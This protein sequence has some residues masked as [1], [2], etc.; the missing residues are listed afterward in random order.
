LLGGFGDQPD[1]SQFAVLVPPGPAGQGT[2]RRDT[3]HG[4]DGDLGHAVSPAWQQHAGREHQ[5][6][7]QGCRTRGQGA[8]RAADRC[9]DGRAH[10]QQRQQSPPRPDHQPGNAD[11]RNNRE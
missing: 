6:N 8:Q 4:Q 10:D 7:S 11:R 9:R 5:P 2:G 1:L 3:G